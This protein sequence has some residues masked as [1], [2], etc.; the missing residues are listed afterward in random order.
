MSSERHRPEGV[1]VRVF[2]AGAML[3][4]FAPVLVMIVFS[5]NDPGGRFNYELHH[6]S[7]AA[8]RHP[9]DVPQLG[10]A[11]RN[12][13][14]V[15]ASS[16]AIAAVLGT[17]IGYVLGR[18]RFPG[19]G[20][21]AALTF[22][23]L[24]TPEVVLGAGLLTLFVATATT[25]P[26]RTITGGLL[27]PLGLPTVIAA[28]VTLGVSFVIINVRSRVVGA[29]PVL[30]EAARDLGAS[31]ATAFRTVWLPVIWPGIA[32]GAL[33]AFAISLDDFVL[34]NFTGGGTVMFPTWVYGLVRRELPPQVAVVGVLIFLVALGAALGAVLL[35]ARGRRRLTPG[36]EV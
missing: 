6:F 7:L 19:R 4:L 26:L 35:G 14:V 36:G 12:S 13:L 3:F 32:S 23:P 18:R 1:A 22:V 15:A 9:L 30:E 2:V 25:E 20:A 29:S 33:L 28:H 8:W 17:P 31:A 34:T 24:A 5:F 10:L 27:F 21:A 11:L 16:T